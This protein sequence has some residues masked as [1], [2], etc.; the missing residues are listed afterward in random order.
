[1]ATFQGTN[2]NDMQTGALNEPN[3]FFNFGIGGDVLQ[4]GSFRDVFHMAIDGAGDFIDG[5]RS[6]DVIDYSGAVRPLTVVL[7]NNGETGYV[8]T[9]SVTVAKVRNVEDVIGS[10]YNDTVRGNDAANAIEG[11]KGDDSLDGGRGDDLLIGGAGKDTLTGGQGS[12]TVSYANSSAGMNIVLDESFS[13]PESGIQGAGAYQITSNGFVREDTFSGVENAIG[14]SFNDIIRGNAERNTL[15]GSG[16]NDTILSAIDGQNDQIIGGNGIDLIDYTGWILDQDLEVTLGEGAGAGQTR[17]FSAQ[18]ATF[19]VEDTLFGIENV[20]GAAGNDGIAGNSEANTLLGGDG[21]DTLTGRGGADTLIGGV[22]QDDFVYTDATDSALTNPD[23]ILGFQRN[24]DQI[25]LRGL[26]NETADQQPL[27]LI[28]GPF[29]GEA[30]EVTLTYAG[31]YVG[32]QVNVDLD[33]DQASDF[34]VNVRQSGWQGPLA[35]DFLF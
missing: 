14:S 32:W 22:G 18:T 4:G 3:E 34:L 10:Q 30:G 17:V 24:V 35:S 5:G 13:S 12:D 6:R 29:T 31:V 27:N 23:V 8:A 9:G 11:G 1:M 25:D 26:A 16:G 20:V 7:E 19:I 28:S 15:D 2:G 33:G 21:N